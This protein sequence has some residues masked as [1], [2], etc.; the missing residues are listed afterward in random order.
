MRIT[1][2]CIAAAFSAALAAC[3]LA[4]GHGHAPAVR[5]VLPAVQSC[6]ALQSAGQAL[7]VLRRRTLAAARR[8]AQALLLCLAAA[9][10]ALTL[11][12]VTELWVEPQALPAGCTP[13]PRR[14]RLPG[15]GHAARPGRSTPPG[16]SAAPARAGPDLPAEHKP[17]R[18]MPRLHLVPF[19]AFSLFPS[20]LPG[21]PDGD[22]SR[23]T[24]E[25]I[26]CLHR[27]PFPAA[28]ARCRAESS[29][30]AAQP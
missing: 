16:R 23:N 12:A 8:T 22:M 6:P 11:P 9:A 29:P 20:P 15:R 1:A 3:C 13:P 10:A 2:P 25:A 14:L 28:A 18:R 4:A 19:S 27:P 17:G 30:A 5:P 26:C 21:L 7:T 24:A